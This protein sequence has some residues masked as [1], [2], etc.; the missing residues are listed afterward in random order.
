MTTTGTVPPASDWEPGVPLH[1]HPNSFGRTDGTYVREMFQLID[2]DR[3]HVRRFCDDYWMKNT[4]EVRCI[5]CLVS[6]APKAGPNCWMCGEPGANYKDACDYLNEEMRRNTSRLV[7]GPRDGEYVPMHGN[8]HPTL[9]FPVPD[10]WPISEATEPEV[11]IQTVTYRRDHY[12]TV[13]HRW[14]YTYQEET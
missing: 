1:E 7:G 14:V 3:I 10:T 5:P 13:T 12:D 2:E 6:W 9:V 8:D 11:T 4:C